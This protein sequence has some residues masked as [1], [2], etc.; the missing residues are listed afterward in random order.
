VKSGPKRRWSDRLNC[1]DD[2]EGWRRAMHERDHRSIY[3]RDPTGPILVLLWICYLG[4]MLAVFY[5]VG[6]WIIDFVRGIKLR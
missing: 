4:G 3:S 1:E 6:S 5:L 2:D